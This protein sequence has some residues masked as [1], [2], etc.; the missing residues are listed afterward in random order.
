MTCSESPK[1]VALRR[2]NLA[3]DIIIALGASGTAISG[4]AVWSQPHLQYVWVTF[5][6][7]AAVVALIKPLLQWEKGL[8][9]Y[10]KLYSGHASNYLVLKDLVSRIQAMRDLT[11]EMYGELEAVIAAHRELAKDDDP[12]PPDDEL[13]ELQDAVE[14]QIPAKTLWLKP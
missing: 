2:K 10:S 13:R 12:S 8:E 14:R 9:R 6:G 4:W 7:S 5:A 11:P 1:L 3:A